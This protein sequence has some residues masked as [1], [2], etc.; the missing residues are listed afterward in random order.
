VSGILS[1]GGRTDRAR[2]VLVYGNCQAPFMAHMLSAL[3]DLNDDYRFVYAPNMVVPGDESALEV[4]DE[5]LRDVAL[6]LW[7][8]EDR[9]NNPAAVALRARLP[10]GVPVL[11]FPSFVLNCLWP[12]ICPEPRGQPEPAYPWKRYPLGDMIALQIAQSGLRGPIA[13]AAYLDLSARKMPNLQVRLERDLAQMRHYDT[14]CDVQLADYALENFRDQHLFWT[15][16]H[17]SPAGVTE[18]ARRVANVARPFLGGT[19]AR[20]ESC[21]AAAQDVAV[22]GNVQLPIHPIVAETLGLRFWQHDLLYQWGP[23]RWTFYDYMERYIAYDTN[24]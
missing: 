6:V 17:L 19:P 8:F 18:L 15:N 10:A 1:Y 9:A 16:G 21:F 22:M 3:D 11:T 23:E 24:W 4:P 12:F 20:M 5:D 2:T 14:Q 7:Q 13:V